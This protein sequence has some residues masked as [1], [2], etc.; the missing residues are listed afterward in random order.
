MNASLDDNIG[1]QY[2][3]HHQRPNRY[4]IPE[5]KYVKTYQVC[6]IYCHLSKLKFLKKYVIKLSL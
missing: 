1:T 4:L 3:D 5:F 2:L 6:Y